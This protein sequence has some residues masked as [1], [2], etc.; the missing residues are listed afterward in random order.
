M[1]VAFTAFCPCGGTI[2]LSLVEGSAPVT[3][4]PDEP[5]RSK[6]WWKFW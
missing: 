5:P 3:D 4:G 1:P 2:A 6:P